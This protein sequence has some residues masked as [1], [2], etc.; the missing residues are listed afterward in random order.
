MTSARA[1]FRLHLLLG[2]LALATVAVAAAVTLRA[3]DV[4]PSSLGDIVATCRQ[5]LVPV[6]RVE[7]FATLALLALGALSALVASRAARSAV[8][9]L[10]ATRRFMATLEVVGPVADTP[11]ALL[12]GDRRPLAFCA[13]YLRP[14]IYVSSG[15]MAL[16]S[17]AQLD[18]VLAHEAHHV[19]RRDPLR[20]L[21]ARTLAE[22]A[23][24]VPV[25][26]RSRERYAALAELAADDAAVRASGRPGPLAAALLAF[27]VNGG[28]AAGVAPE[29]VD[30]LAGQRSSWQVPMRDVMNGIAT[31]GV[32]GIVISA[33]ALA[34]TGEGLSVAAVAMSGC[35]FFILAAPVLL[36]LASHQY[37]AAPPR[38]RLTAPRVHR[39]A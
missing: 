36:A 22:S 15:T 25:L 38:R 37:L 8:R 11:G 19:R 10:V 1:L 24:F 27:D 7:T 29:R 3:V 13:G 35:T 6:W 17:G 28:P 31:I 34:S 30:H 20:M 12:I 21:V 9:Q 23:F 18:A 33:T 2:A 39:S 26:H 16:L 4:A 32:L 14:R 5:A